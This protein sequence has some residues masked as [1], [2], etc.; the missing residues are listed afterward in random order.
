MSLTTPGE[1]NL[2]KCTLCGA[3]A[4]ECPADALTRVGKYYTPEELV[5]ELVRDKLFYDNSGGGVTLSGGEPTLFM[6]YTAQIAKKLNALNIHVCMETCMDFDWEQFETK[7][8]PYLSLIYADIKLISENLHK[9]FTGRDNRRIQKNMALA[10]S[11]KSPE[12]LFRV[13]LIPDAVATESNLQSIADWLRE[14]KVNRIALLPYNPLW[15]PKVLG[16]KKALKYNCQ[17]W[18]TPSEREKAK[19]IF[20]KF[21]I[22]GQTL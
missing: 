14:H 18:L 9:D 1:R 3:C 8:L 19:K 20:Q 17:T 7:L 12:I 10:L 5:E 11:C 15:T 13:P 16:L 22:V 6:D 21:E 4:K 2:K